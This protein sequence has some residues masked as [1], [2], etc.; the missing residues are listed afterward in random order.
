MNAMFTLGQHWYFPEPDKILTMSNRF[1]AHMSSSHASSF[2]KCM[3]CNT[4]DKFKSGQMALHKAVLIEKDTEG[5]L[6]GNSSI[7]VIYSWEQKETVLGEV[8]A[9]CNEE[10]HCLFEKVRS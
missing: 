10:Q 6:C 1:L 3:H 5:V 9:P 2:H 8:K 7:S 4:Y